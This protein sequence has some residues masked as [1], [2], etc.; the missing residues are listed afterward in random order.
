VKTYRRR[1]T[2]EPVEYNCLENNRNPVGADGVAQ[3]VLAGDDG[4][5]PPSSFGASAPAVEAAPAVNPVTTASGPFGK[6]QM[7]RATAVSLGNMA[8][9][10]VNVE[11]RRLAGGAWTWAAR[12]PTGRW[13]CMAEASGK[14]PYCER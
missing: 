8:W 11:D 4:F 13:R 14:N 7:Q 3:V 1:P 12:T 6:E 9:E 2:W 5:N 10:S